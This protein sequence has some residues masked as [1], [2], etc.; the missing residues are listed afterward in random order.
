MT[1]YLF[2]VQLALCCENFAHNLIAR[3][4]G[5]ESHHCGLPGSSYL[6]CFPRYKQ[7]MYSSHV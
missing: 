7:T 5:E 3:S 6:P 2:D 1:K 4:D